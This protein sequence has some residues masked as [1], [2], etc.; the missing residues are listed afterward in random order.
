M[1]TFVSSPGLNYGGKDFLGKI[2]PIIAG[3]RDAAGGG[4]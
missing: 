2:N 1:T 4:R 3:I